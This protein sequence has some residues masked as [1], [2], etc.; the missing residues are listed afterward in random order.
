[1]HATDLDVAALAQ[2][3]GEDCTVPAMR[4]RLRCEKCG[5]KDVALTLSPRRTGGISG[6]PLVPAS[7]KH[8]L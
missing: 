1:M 3:L 8:V 2:R 6:C 7:R 4:D 5:N